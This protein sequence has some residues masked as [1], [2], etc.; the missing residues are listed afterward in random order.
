MGELS[1][2]VTLMLLQSC[3]CLCS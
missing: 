3:F 1:P 2:V